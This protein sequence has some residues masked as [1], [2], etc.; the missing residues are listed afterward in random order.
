[1]LAETGRSVVQKLLGPVA[2]RLPNLS[3]NAVTL[4]A[5]GVALGAGAALALTDQSPYFFLAAAALGTVYGLLDALDGV[6]ARMHGK[7]SAWGD[8]LDHSVD[9]LSALFALGGLTL[10]RHCNDRL[11]LVLMVGTLFHGF[12]G[13]QI[14]A[15]FRRRVYRGLGIAESIGLVIFYSLT[16][17]AIRELGLPFYFRDP[18]TGSILSVTDTFILAG[19]PLIV[20]GTIQRFAIARDLAREIE[21]GRPLAEEACR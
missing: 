13:T 10:A 2:A 5:L 6:L 3:P 14:Q 12:L 4:A 19:L 8:F 7:Q 1:M 20:V 9:R 11:G 17:F 15:S 18:F 16:A 21:A